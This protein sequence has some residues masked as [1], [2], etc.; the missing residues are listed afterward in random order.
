ML[1]AGCRQVPVPSRKTPPAT[2]KA[3]TIS[4][5]D[6]QLYAVAWVGYDDLTE[7]PFYLDSYV[8]S[9]HVPTH[10]FSGGEYYLIIP[11]YSDMDLKLYKNDIAVEAPTLV[12]EESDC[13]PFLIQCNVSD[14]F[15]DATISFTRGEDTAEFSPYISLKD[16]SI[17]V[18]ERGLN[19]TK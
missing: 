9:D 11:R 14:I 19:L 17:E 6:D 13:R 18:G 1:L 10:Y 15:P 3:E 2:S 16:G 7:L 12:Y 4:F 8:D 5:A